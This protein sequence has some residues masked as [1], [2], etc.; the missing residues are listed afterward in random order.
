[1]RNGK[2]ETGN[3]S[4]IGHRYGIQWSDDITS[5]ALQLRRELTNMVSMSARGAS[6][7]IPGVYVPLAETIRAAEAILGGE[8]DKYPEA[9]FYNVGTI[10]DVAK[11]ARE[12]GG[13]A[14]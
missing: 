8:T 12:E 1:M 6:P 4:V 13:D 3:Y 14:K 11:R 2:L 5:E 9:A 7:Y 10:D